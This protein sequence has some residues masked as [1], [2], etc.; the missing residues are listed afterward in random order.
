MLRQDLSS[1]SLEL[2]AARVPFV[3]AR[4]VLAERPTSAKPGDEAI[5][6]GDG[7]LEGFVGGACAETT[8]RDESIALLRSGGTTLLR[9]TPVAESAQP[10]KRVVH[11]PCLSGGTLEVFLEPSVPPPLIVVVGSAP[12]ANALVSLGAA[13][14][15]SAE[16]Y[17]GALPPDAAAVVV[18]SHGRG[19]EQAL[20]AA[21]DAN[22]PYIGLVASAK[23]GRV[24]LDSLGLTEQQR[25]LIHTPA[26]LDF[27]AGTPEE[28]ALSILAEIVA[29][30]PNPAVARTPP[31]AIAPAA[32]TTDP[33]C[34]MT[35]SPDDYGPHLEVD[36]GVV[37]FCGRGCLEAFAAD[38]SA[39]RT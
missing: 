19:E 35:V 34:G 12:I 29:T 10:G 13:L 17:N 1:R 30:R 18:A 4:V 22:V 31:A 8:V 28:V 5:I 23:R 36:A 32:H 11:N 3:Y 38:P 7:T 25:A 39:Y 14:R 26:G 20:A 33:V 16:R 37:W 2:R 27:G 24:V 15:Y 9:I 21:L 6:L